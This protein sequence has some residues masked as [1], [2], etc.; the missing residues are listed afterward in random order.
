[1]SVSDRW[2]KTKPAPGDVPC[3][4]HSRGTTR[5][6]PTEDHL[7]GDRWLVRWRDENGEQCKR[8]FPKKSG[9]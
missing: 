8:S 4:E 9:T 3:K 7:R 2:H 6:Y 1:M 5:L